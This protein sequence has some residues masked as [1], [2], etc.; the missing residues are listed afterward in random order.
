MTDPAYYAIPR[1]EVLS[2][3]AGSWPPV[4]GEPCLHLPPAA[5]I[6]DGAVAVYPVEGRPGTTWWVVDST[7]YRQDAGTPSGDLAALIPDA[8][9]DTVPTAAQPPD[10]PPAD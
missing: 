9:L 2:Y 10:A 6:T 5:G 7:V 4:P 1:D 8:L 3:L